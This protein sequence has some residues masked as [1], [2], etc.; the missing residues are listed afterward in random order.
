MNN[1]TNNEP[2]N[3]NGFKEQIKIKYKSTEAITEKFPNG[4]AALMWLFTNVK[5]P[6]DLAAY[7]TLTADQNLCGN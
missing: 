7:F 4:T 1:Y 2:Y 5:P 6:L 3:P